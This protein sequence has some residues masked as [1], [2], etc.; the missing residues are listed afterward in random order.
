MA[1]RSS[2][3]KRIYETACGF[4]DADHINT[5]VDELGLDAESQLRR[6]SSL[7]DDAI[8]SGEVVQA[9]GILRDIRDIVKDANGRAQMRN[10]RY[11]TNQATPANK[12]LDG[13]TIDD[14]ILPQ[15]E[16]THEDREDEEDDR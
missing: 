15:Q 8:E 2:K 13:P 9:R 11:V 16:D 12:Q 1:K 4:L 10:I 6:L 3:S 5:V 7:L 14:A